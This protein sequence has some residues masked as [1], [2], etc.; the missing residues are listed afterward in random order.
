MTRLPDAISGRGLPCLALVLGLA[1]RSGAALAAVPSN[2]R[3]V[4]DIRPGVASSSPEELFAFGDTLLFTADDGVHGTEL[5]R[6]DGT[7]QG[8]MLVQDINPG[9]DPS[10][11][12]DFAS[13]NGVAFFTADDGVHGRELWRTDGTPQGT[14]LVKDINPGVLYGVYPGPLVPLG[15]AVYFVGYQPATG[16]ELWGSDGTAD[17]TWL[18]KDIYPGPGPSEACGPCPEC[19]HR[20]PRYLAAM[21]GVLYFAAADS[22]ECYSSGVFDTEL[23]R[24]NGKESG[25]WRVRDITP[26]GW[27][28][29]PQNLTAVDGALYFRAAFSLFRS[30]GTE[31]GTQQVVSAPEPLGLVAAATRL[32]FTAFDSPTTFNVDLWR[33]APPE[34]GASLVGRIFPQELFAGCGGGLVAI[35]DNLLLQ[36]GDLDRGCELWRSDGTGPGTSAVA[37]I[38]PGP[39]HSNPACLTRAPNGLVYFRA[40]DGV[41]AASGETELWRTDGT[42]QG[43]RLVADLKPGPL[44]SSPGC[45]V[46]AGR[47]L[48]FSADDGNAGRELWAVDLD[49]LFVDGFEGP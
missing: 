49:V 13:V 41:S 2:V 46:A 20:S 16:A 40:A 18:V 42:A 10:N 15:G 8:T 39:S 30:D 6:S 28:S 24:S 23:W 12:W 33:T 4:R 25:T 48:Y 27:G 17:G 31:Q 36:G 44:G 26:G 43:T 22:G 19:G 14:V 38:Y 35:G 45:A 37:D 21:G 3:L 34:A 1:L 7:P 11:P 32:F 47:Y 29:I 5:W 9:P